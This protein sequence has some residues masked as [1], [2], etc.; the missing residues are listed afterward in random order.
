MSAL[1]GPRAGRQETIKSRNLVLAA[2][3]AVYA[4]GVAAIDT[5][6]NVVTKQVAGNANLIAVGTF[7]ASVDNSGSTATAYVHVTLSREINCY[8]LD[9]ATGANAV[10]AANLYENVYMLDDHTVTTASSS[11]AVSGRVW[12]VD[13]TRGVLVQFNGF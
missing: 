7:E 13:A 8:W 6:A 4:G 1:S 2:S 9:S 3:T 11:N 5:S 10:T 12:D